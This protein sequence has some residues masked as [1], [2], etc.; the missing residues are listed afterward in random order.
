MA[1]AG[2]SGL[3]SILE[4]GSGFRAGSRFRNLSP[5]FTTSAPLSRRPWRLPAWLRPCLLYTSD[6]ADDM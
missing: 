3:V 2:P 4:G 1:R 5:A 6:A